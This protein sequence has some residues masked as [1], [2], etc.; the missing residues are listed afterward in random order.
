MLPDSQAG[1]VRPSTESSIGNW[2]VRKT[3]CQ[4]CDTAYVE[5][6]NS[7]WQT[8]VS[9]VIVAAAAAGL[10]W[11]KFR[12]RKFNFHRDT[13]CGCAT[14]DQSTTHQSIIFRARKGERPQVVV[15]RK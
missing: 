13:H 8:V 3:N 10:L 12:K 14:P 4:R 1:S 6:V 15:K 11:A 5:I 9:L 7:D 2:I